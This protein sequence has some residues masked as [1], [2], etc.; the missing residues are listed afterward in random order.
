MPHFLHRDDLLLYCVHG[1]IRIC[2]WPYTVAFLHLISSFIVLVA[3]CDSLRKE[4]LI[5]LLVSDR[6][7]FQEIRFV[8]SFRQFPI[9]DLPFKSPLRLESHLDHTNNYHCHLE[10]FDPP[11]TWLNSYNLASLCP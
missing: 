3:L 9:P 1:V 11:T 5:V 10:L 7:S 8:L 4:V 2:N 6:H